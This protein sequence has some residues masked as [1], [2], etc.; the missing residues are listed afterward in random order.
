MFVFFGLYQSFKAL[1]VFLHKLLCPDDPRIGKVAGAKG[2]ALRAG[3][4]KVLCL[5]FFQHCLL[6]LRPFAGFDCTGFIHKF[7]VFPQPFPVRH[8]PE[9]SEAEVKGKECLTVSGLSVIAQAV[10]AVVFRFFNDC[11]PHRVQVNIG[12]AV[13]QGIA[14]FNNN[15]LKPLTPEKPPAAMALVLK[16]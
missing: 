7:S 4:R 1:K 10:P 5:L 9:L 16:A 15:A 6:D 13:Y 8:L 12:Q 11:G 2:K 3:Q 14:V